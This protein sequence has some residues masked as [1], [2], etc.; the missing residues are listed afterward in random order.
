[1]FTLA[2]HKEKSSIAERVQCNNWEAY[3]SVYLNHNHAH[4]GELWLQFTNDNMTTSYTALIGVCNQ[5]NTVVLFLC[6]NIKS[7]ISDSD[8][9]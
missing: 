7:D 8:Q 2:N 6:A 9:W 3:I 1:M 5:K 4:C